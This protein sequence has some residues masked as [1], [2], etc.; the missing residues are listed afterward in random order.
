V[1]RFPFVAGGV[2]EHESQM[3]ALC[4]LQRVGHRRCDGGNGLPQGGEVHTRKGR[5]EHEKVVTTEFDRLAG[6]GTVW[7]CN[8]VAGLP[9]ERQDL[10]PALGIPI[11]Y[12]NEERIN[13]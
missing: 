10:L 11:Q 8:L 13:A 1:S 6:C 4:I 3:A 9:Q 2:P 7:D 5:I 12:Q